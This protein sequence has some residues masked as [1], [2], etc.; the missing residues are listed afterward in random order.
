MLRVVT[1]QEQ[2][3]QSK[4]VQN[5]MRRGVKERRPPPLYA[6][7]LKDLYVREHVV[8]GNDLLPKICL[9]LAIPVQLEK[10]ILCILIIYHVP[11]YVLMYIIFTNLM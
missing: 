10:I 6:Y 3:K 5:E 4:G 2:L 8:F 9:Q 1:D 11:M 7:E